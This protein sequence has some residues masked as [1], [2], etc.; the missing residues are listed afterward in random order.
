[1]MILPSWAVLQITNSSNRPTTVGLLPDKVGQRAT[2]HPVILIVPKKTLQA[3]VLSPTSSTSMH[4]NTRLKKKGHGGSNVFE[5]WH[6]PL[7]RS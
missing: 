5:P 1:M 6:R 2:C 7:A 4:S 3:P